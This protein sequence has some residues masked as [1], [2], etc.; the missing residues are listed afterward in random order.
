M[1]FE[2]PRLPVEWAGGQDSGIEGKA[3]SVSALFMR[4]QTTVLKWGQASPA[5]TLLAGDIE[6]ASLTRLPARLNVSF[7][8]PMPLLQVM[9]HDLRLPRQAMPTARTERAPFRRAHI[10]DVIRPISEAARA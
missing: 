4:V 10:V 1:R 6:F 5:V 3:C 8:M 7:T 2:L 9:C